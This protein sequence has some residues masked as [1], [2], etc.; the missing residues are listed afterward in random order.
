[1]LAPSAGRAYSPAIMGIFNRDYS[2]AI[3]LPQDIEHVC[4]RLGL[5]CLRHNVRGLIDYLGRPEKLGN[6]NQKEQDY[7]LGY[8]KRHFCR[9]DGHFQTHSLHSDVEEKLTEAINSFCR[10]LEEHK[11]ISDPTKTLFEQA[12]ALSSGDAPQAEDKPA[13]IRR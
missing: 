3:A 4:D 9:E 5:L 7:L 8:F 11:Q 6:L 13:L 2:G 10:D 1:M 12:R